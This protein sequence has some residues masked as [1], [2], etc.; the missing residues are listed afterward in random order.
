MPGRKRRKEKKEKEKKKPTTSQ[1]KLSPILKS[2][3]KIISRKIDYV[4]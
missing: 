3:R 4:W 2:G 1:I